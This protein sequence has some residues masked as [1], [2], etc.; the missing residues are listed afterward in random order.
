MCETGLRTWT[1]C[2]DTLLGF[3]KFLFI[4]DTCLVAIGSDFYIFDEA[5]GGGAKGLWN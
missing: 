3:F 2:L 4:G 5:G 1:S